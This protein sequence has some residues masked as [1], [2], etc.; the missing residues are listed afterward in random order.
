VCGAAHG[1]AVP[2]SIVVRERVGYDGILGRSG[3][4]ANYVARRVGPLG[5][6]DRQTSRLGFYE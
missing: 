5:Q 6:P 1:P 2:A 4:D 3:I